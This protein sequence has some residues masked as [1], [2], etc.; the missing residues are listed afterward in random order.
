MSE[1][2]LRIWVV[3]GPPLLD[4][5]EDESINESTASCNILFSFLKIISGA[6]KLISLFKRLFLLITLLYK[7]FKS[8]VAKRPPGSCTIGRRSG[9][10]TG[11]TFIINHSGWICAE[12]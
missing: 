1:R 4:V 8:E 6:P 10:K 7:S 12:R 5:F 11:K 2:D 3:A 9:G